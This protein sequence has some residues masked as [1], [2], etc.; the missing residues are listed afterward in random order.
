MQQQSFVH[1]VTAKIHI[2]AVDDEWWPQDPETKTKVA[3]LSGTLTTA[4]PA[5]S[6]GRV[7]LGVGGELR[8]EVDVYATA[9]A[10]GK[11]LIEGEARLYEGTSEKSQDLDGRKKFELVVEKNTSRSHSIRVKNVDEGGDYADVS[12]RF[13]NSVRRTSPTD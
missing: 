10:Y 11:I 2:F 3:V 5:I 12:M 4:E 7:T 13:N 8:I 1:K 9:L 6:M